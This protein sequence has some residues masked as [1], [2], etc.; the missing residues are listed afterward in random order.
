MPYQAIR[1][2]LAAKFGVLPSEIDK[3]KFPEVAEVLAVLDGE[4]KATS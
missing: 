4:A 3:L 1:V 2:L